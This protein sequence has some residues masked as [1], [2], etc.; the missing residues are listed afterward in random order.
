MSERRPILLSIVG[1]ITVISGLLQILAG[2]LLLILKDDVVQESAFT[3]DEVTALAI[4]ALVVGLIYFLVGRG[5]L[6]LNAFALGLGVVVSAL[7]LGANLIYLLG[8]N[9]NH[10]GLIASMIV[11][12]IVLV[13]CVS[14]FGARD[15][16][17]R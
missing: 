16:L 14:G 3:S 9:D 10:G 13:A 17:R 15:G 2:I 11:N 8:S 1:W 4:V 7:A 12:V 6:N 5:M